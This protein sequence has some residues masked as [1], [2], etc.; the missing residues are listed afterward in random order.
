MT[1]PS[2]AIQ[3]A[4]HLARLVR[5]RFLMMHGNDV[6]GVFPQAFAKRNGE[7][8]LSLTWIEWF[9]PYSIQSKKAAVRALR[10]DSSSKKL[11]QAH[12]AIGLV[13]SIK[14]AAASSS[15]TTSIE[16]VLGVCRSMFASLH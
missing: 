13:E 3:E 4:D 6:V 2:P 10:D 15:S 8:Y 7:E 14:S 16:S 1:E 12:L 9:G 5:H 11:G